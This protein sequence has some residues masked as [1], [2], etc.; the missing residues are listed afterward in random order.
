MALSGQNVT[1]L[2]PADAG[3]GEFAPIPDSIRDS[4]HTLPL[5]M[6]PLESRS[7]RRSLM[8]KNS[9]CESVVEVFKGEGS[10][11]GQVDVAQLPKTFKNLT[12]GDLG[13]LKKL[14]ELPSYD[15]YSLR[16]VLRDL[17]IPINDYEELRLS[18]DKTRELDAYMKVFTRPLLAQVYGDDGTVREFSDIIQL[19]RQPDVKKARDQLTLLAEKLG[20]DI[21]HIPGFLQDY[22]DTYLSVSYY[23]QCLDQ[24]RPVEVNVQAA[25]AE[26]ISHPQLSLD[27]E[28]VQ[29]CKMISTTL[30]QALKN[31]H[32]RFELFEERTLDMWD[33]ITA[34][35][36]NEVRDFILSNHALLG[37]I[38]CGLTLCMDSW[39]EKFPDEDS[40]GPFRRAE[41]VR[42]ELRRG[43]EHVQGV[44]V[45]KGKD[46]KSE[47][48]E[49]G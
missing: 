7:I 30:E 49:A 14:S 40:V 16:I 43:V 47:E 38:L 36:F 21:W 45:P 37:G 41:Y 8:I 5:S 46:A 25:L 44:R 3:A 6:I 31:I 39:A 10:G 22:G 33:G 24:V 4:L 17:Q 27:Q 13:I 35:R 48:Q 12:P 29:T 11:S 26:L 34:D 15:V 1:V 19:F 32:K 2:E 28:C 20:V 18:A 23:R 9:R 42:N